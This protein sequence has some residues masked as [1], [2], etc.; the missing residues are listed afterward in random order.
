MTYGY[1]KEKLNIGHLLDLGIK[2]VQH[3]ACDSKTAAILLMINNYVSLQ[4]KDT[5]FVTGLAKSL[6]IS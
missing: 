1:Y 3:I 5:E 4:M 2:K 6:N